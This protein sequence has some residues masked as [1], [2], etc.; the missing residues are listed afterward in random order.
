[1]IVEFKDLENILPKSNDQNLC[2][3]VFSTAIV[4][5][6]HFQHKCN[7]SIKKLYEYV[8][9]RLSPDKRFNSRN[10]SKNLENFEIDIE[11]LPSTMKVFWKHILDDTYDSSCM[12]H[13]YRSF[14]DKI[15]YTKPFNFKVSDP[16]LWDWNPS[17]EDILF[18]SELE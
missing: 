13:Y 11:N 17:K 14:L 15:L 12:N 6:Y 4:S 2:I 8:E 7:D 1:M 9:K 16:F 10:W 3:E 5:C 18:I